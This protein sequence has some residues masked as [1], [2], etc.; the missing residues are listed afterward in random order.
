MEIG[1]TLIKKASIFANYLAETFQPHNSILLP[2]RINI[3]EQF[4]N[5]PLQIFLP[6]KHTSSAEVQYTI[7]KLPRKKSPGNDLLT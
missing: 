6:P 1:Y 4:L 3:V 7:S 2:E 5:L